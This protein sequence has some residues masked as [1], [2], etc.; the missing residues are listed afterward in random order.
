MAISLMR[1]GTLAI[2][3]FATASG[4][5]RAIIPD[6]PPTSLWTGDSFIAGAAITG[7]IT[8]ITFHLRSATD[9]DAATPQTATVSAGRA[10]V[11]FVAPAPANGFRVLA[12]DPADP[13]NAALSAAFE[14]TTRP[15][16]LIESGGRL[17][18]EQGGALQI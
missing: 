10:E 11:T 1:S 9:V 4:V 12:V 7:P 18:L 2:D 15:R 8:Q 6:A 5:A 14:V 13:L 3:V 17:L 16:L